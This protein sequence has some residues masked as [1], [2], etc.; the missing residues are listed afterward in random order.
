MH[1]PWAGSWRE[2][3][4]DGREGLSSLESA[5]GT[6]AS[7]PPTRGGGGGGGDE[8]ISCITE[9]LSREIK[10]AHISSPNFHNC[11]S[12]ID[13][14][15]FFPMLCECSAPQLSPLQANQS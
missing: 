4:A 10:L 5:P 13:K 14:Q 1:S 12:K 8:A 7:S 15:V 9:K 11:E 2:S 3:V 6:A